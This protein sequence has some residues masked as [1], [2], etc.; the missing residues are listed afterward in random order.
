MSDETGRL[1]LRE[2]GQLRTDIANLEISLEVTMRQLARMPTR[3]DL[4]RAVL[5]GMLGGAA[6]AT[7]P[8]LAFSLH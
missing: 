1:M 2:A 3:K 7:A 5:M 4:W 8:A 6:L